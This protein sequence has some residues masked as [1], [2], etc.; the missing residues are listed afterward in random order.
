MKYLTEEERRR[1]AKPFLESVIA[2]RPVREM[3]KTRMVDQLSED[4][5]MLLIEAAKHP[6]KTLT[7]LYA[8]AGL[9]ASFG[10]TVKDDLRARE[11]VFQHEHA[12]KGQGG[13]SFVLEVL[14]AGREEL[15]KHDICPVDKLVGRGS[16]MHDVYARYVGKYEEAQGNRV[17]YGKW[18]GGK[19]FDV[20][21]EGDE[22]IK[23]YEIVLSGAAKWNASQAMKAASV[24]GVASVTVACKSTRLLNEIKKRLREAEGDE[25]AKKKIEC[26]LLADFV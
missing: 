9:H 25:E 4:S 17:S 7:E 19:E 10:G 13:Q 21:S 2:I 22:A 6:T 20:F 15:A 3:P 14:E 1:R 18:F 12:R 24:K 11:M 5:L 26:V 8:G 16:F 23:C